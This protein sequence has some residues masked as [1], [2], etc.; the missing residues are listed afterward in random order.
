MFLLS[1]TEITW[2]VIAS[3]LGFL[4]ISLVVGVILTY[5]VAKVIYFKLFVRREGIWGR[6]CSDETVDYHLDMYNQGLEWATKNKEHAKE[7]YIKSNDGLALFG[8]F[9]DFGYKTTSIITPGRS[10]ALTY[11]YFYAKGYKDIKSNVLVVDQRGHG[12]SEGTYSTAGIKE[13]DDLLLW[14]KYLHD[15]LGQESIFLHGICVGSSASVIAAT[16]KDRPNYIKAVIVDSGFINLTEMIRTHTI[17]YG[18]P[19]FPV[20]YEMNHWFKKY[21][22]VDITKTT[23]QKEIK[24]LDLP[25]LMVHT[26]V[27]KFAYAKYAQGLFDSCPSKDKE[28]H[29]FEDGVHSHLRYYHPEEYDK[30]LKGFFTKYDAK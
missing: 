13:A 20:V 19:T 1:A 3:V 28:I 4:L 25:L 16:R 2:I 30:L 6:Q 22:G 27:D 17:D 24:K 18:K 14:S 23:M 12:K 5:Q 15:E 21:A 26:K 29:F 7:V 9:Y 10:E 8:E 11:S